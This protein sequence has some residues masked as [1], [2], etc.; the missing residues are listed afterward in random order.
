MVD[1]E[2]A[3]SKKETLLR[4]LKGLESLL[5]AFSGG[6]DSSFLLAVAHQA[7]GEKVLAATARST[8]Y[9]S[10]EL[11][12]ASEFARK[13]GIQ[14]VVFESDEAS[15]PDFLSNSPNRCYHCKKSLSQELQ[16]VAKERDIQHIAHAANLDDLDDYRPGLKAAQEMGIMAPLVDARLNKEEIRFLSKEMGLST[17]DKPA[18]ACLASRIPYG[19]PITEEKLKMIEAAEAFLAKEG[20]RQFRVRHHGPVARIEVE[21]SDIKR[22]VQTELRKKIVERF[23]EIGFLH[24]ALDLEGYVT[25][26]LNRALD[27]IE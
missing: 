1:K 21:G 18:M 5:V 4:H 26:S 16:R 6:V 9:P 25:G 8:T 20:F 17:W 2:K 27:H 3:R 23:R 10:K 24:I 11:Q 7:L 14:Q 13:R 22:I 15:L 19:E 12:E